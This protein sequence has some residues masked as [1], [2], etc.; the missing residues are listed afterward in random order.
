MHDINMAE[1]VDTFIHKVSNDF[2][3][4]NTN[5]NGVLVT[6]KNGLTI[7]S[8]GIKNDCSGSIALL[9]DLASTLF[10]RPAIVCLENGDQKV[11]IRE[12]GKTVFTIYTEGT[13]R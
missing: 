5:I 7:A 8:Q 10:E 4:S 13:R 3:A 1:A 2:K 12:S 9:S 11:I 6:D